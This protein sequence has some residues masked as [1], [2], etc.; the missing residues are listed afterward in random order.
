MRYKDINIDFLYHSVV[1]GDF[2]LPDCGN[3]QERM[4]GVFRLTDDF[5]EVYGNYIIQNYPNGA[6]V[7]DAIE[8]IKK[9]KHLEEVNI[10]THRDLIVDFMYSKSVLGFATYEYFSYGL[11]NKSIEDRLTFMKHRNIFQYYGTL[12]TDVNC[13]RKLGSKYNTYSTFKRYFKREI[14]RV[15]NGTDKEKLQAFASTHDSFMIKPVGSALGKGIRLIRATD[16][17]SIDELF[18]DIFQDGTVV[19]EE[20]IIP[21]SS[22]VRINPS[23]VNTVRIF[24][25]YNGK[26]VTIVCAWMKAGRGNAVV[27]NAGAGGMLAAIDEATGVVITDAAD[28]AGGNYKTHPDTGFVFKGFQIPQWSEAIKIVKAMAPQLPGVPLIGWDLALSADKGW[29]VIEGNEGGQISL[30]QIP[31]KKGMLKELT[32]RFE[33]EKHKKAANKK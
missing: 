19:C 12:N 1:N 27:D 24:T 3:T 29:Q 21:H 33:W 32:E 10:D 14:I 20:L 23:C 13:I 30:I 7:R 25:Y 18:T 4:L 28:E 8:A 16:Y 2:M 31:H 11:E 15:R 9:Y 22:F 17:V 6:G 26:A 5:R